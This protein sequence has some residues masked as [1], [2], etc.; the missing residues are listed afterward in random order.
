MAELECLR[1]IQLSNQ[2]TLP[3]YKHKGTY[4]ELSAVGGPV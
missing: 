3:S 1:C 4:S 2:D